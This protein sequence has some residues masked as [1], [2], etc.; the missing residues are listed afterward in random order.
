MYVLDVA[1]RFRERFTEEYNKHEKVQAEKQ[2]ELE[3]AQAKKKS[4]EEDVMRHIVGW[5]YIS[6]FKVYNYDEFNALCEK[7]P[8]IT[9]FS[10]FFVVSY[11]M[12]SYDR[13]PD[14]YGYSSSYER[15]EI[16]YTLK[17]YLTQS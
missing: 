15:R 4:Q 17:E 9:H 7:Y 13:E 5:G 10:D 16:C 14:T 12:V 11:H 3:K 2:R 8:N 6:P 1:K